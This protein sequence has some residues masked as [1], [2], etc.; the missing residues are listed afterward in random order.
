ML[1]SIFETNVIAPLALIQELL[2]ALKEC[3]GL[4]INLSSDAALG[5]YRGWGGYGTSKAALDL[6]SKTLGAELCG[7][8]VVT[9]PDVSG[10]V[11]R[12]GYLGPAPPRGHAALLGL[13][14]RPA[15][16]RAHRP[17][18]PGAGGHLGGGGGSMSLTLADLAFDR[19][20]GLQA[21]TPP[22]R[23]GRDRDD[24]RLLVSDAGGH[25]HS[26][27]TRLAEH[28]APGDLLVANR[29]AT[30][31]ASLP[32][33][34]PFGGMLLNL[35]T[36]YAPDLWLTEPRFGHAEP[37]PLP[38]SAGE[39][40]G[41]AGLEAHLVAP[42]PGLERLWFVRFRG[43]VAAATSAH[44]RPIRYG[45]LERS[46]PLFADRPGS[47]EMPSAGR[48]F[49][50]RVLTTLKAHEVGVATLTLHTGVSS[51]EVEVEDLDDL[52]LYPEPFEVP[53]TTAERV[54]AARSGGHRVIAIGTTVVRALE[55][56]F[57][58]ERVHPSR[59]FTGRFIRPGV[60]G[61]AVNGILTGL[62]DP[63]ATHLAMLYA[64][65][66][67]DAVMEGYAEAVRARYL[68]HEFGDS[69]LILD[70]PA[71]SGRSVAGRTT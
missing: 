10:G 15:P 39:I 53:S 61:N 44:G 69:H 70:G 36:R 58:G 24:V 56:T 12:R 26:H 27:F 50:N 20:P 23:R 64:I 1:R 59:G 31:P 9:H 42:Y 37:G 63:R 38:L 16:T 55:S 66:G 34:G 35:S 45:Y 4:V 48:P 28:L 21:T 25:R 6:I 54:N 68:W 29:S 3:G 14:A 60:G 2:P 57:D 52:T 47:A 33:L 18:V 51:L 43:D 7:V 5:G 19:P 32:A 46:Y 30:L 22:E 41:V 71:G 49:S 13:A 65:A 17:Q 8:A 11:P 40:L 67:R 62:H